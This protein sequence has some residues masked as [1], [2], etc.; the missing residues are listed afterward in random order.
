MFPT[1]LAEME[2]ELSQLLDRYADGQYQPVTFLDRGVQIPFTTPMLLGARAR[3][4]ERGLELVLANPSGGSGHYVIP[5][6]SM[7]EVCSPSLHD[8][9]L[10]ERVA[11]L[12]PPTPGGIKAAAREVAREG[13]AGKAA[14]QAASEAMREEEGRRL[15][16]HFQLLLLLTR[17]VEGPGAAPRIE[18]DSRA[19]QQ[20]RAKR[21]LGRVATRFNAAPELIPAW[22]EQIATFYAEHGV[23]PDAQNAPTPRRVTELR[24]LADAVKRHAAASTRQEESASGQL[25]AEAAELTL[26]AVADPIGR[27]EQMLRDVAE[28]LVHTGQDPRELSALAAQP[29]WLLDGWSTIQD[30]WNVA[31]PAWRGH[32]L[33]EMA[34]LIPVIP[35]EVRDWSREGTE[36]TE[37]GSRHANL[38]R[39]HR[40]VLAREDWRTGRSVDVLARNERLRAL[41]P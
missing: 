9:K 17:Q 4:A 15:V 34:G 11:R 7:P 27:M 24:A 32:A 31:P 26:R 14:A 37:G 39:R 25:I 35:R 29:D 36:W 41:R 5:W 10:Y 38:A 18:T 22:L 3:P 23:G 19:N 2:V 20:E 13:W 28:L 40:Y 6:H 33:A 8:R 30:L 12:M 1:H 21:A 16:T